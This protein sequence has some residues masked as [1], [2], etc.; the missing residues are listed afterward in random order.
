MSEKK[1]AVAIKADL[2]GLYDEAIL[3]SEKIPQN[4]FKIVFEKCNEERKNLL[5]NLY[6]FDA[7]N[8]VYSLKLQTEVNNFKA[9]N[10]FLFKS[11]HCAFLFHKLNEDYKKN[12]EKLISLISEAVFKFFEDEIF[13]LEKCRFFLN[14]GNASF[15]SLSLTR[16]KKTF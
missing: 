1:L 13:I 10:N 3:D 16:I 5:N 8:K 9:L 6:E 11:M 7:A 15:K 14:S 4:E 2:G 12:S